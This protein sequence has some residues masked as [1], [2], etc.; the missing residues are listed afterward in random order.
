M[1]IFINF[2]IPIGL[3]LKATQPTTPDQSVPQAGPRLS[4]R[5]RISGDD[6]PADP[7]EDLPDAPQLPS[8]ERP[9]ER[10]FVHTIESD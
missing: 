2:E 8:E 9:R 7:A 10:I 4:T 6:G 1:K 3:P 5:S